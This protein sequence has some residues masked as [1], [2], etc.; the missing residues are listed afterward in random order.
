MGRTYWLHSTQINNNKL[1]FHSFY[2][3]LLLKTK[4]IFF[5]LIFFFF[6]F[7]NFQSK[8]A[9]SIF[10]VFVCLVFVV[11]LF[12]DSIF[13]SNMKLQLRKS[14]LSYF[15]FHLLFFENKTKRNE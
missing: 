6:N 13:H 7:F 12:V 3:V 15:L 8:K 5:F 2:F 4:K 11:Y 1:D 10:F 9:I 14:R